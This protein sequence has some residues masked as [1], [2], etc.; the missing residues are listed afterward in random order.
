MLSK[1]NRIDRT[2]V[3]IKCMDVLDVWTHVRKYTCHVQQD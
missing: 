1:K 3:L 2:R